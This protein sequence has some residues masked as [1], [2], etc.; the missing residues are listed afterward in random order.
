MNCSSL[1]ISFIIALASLFFVSCEKDEE[2]RQLN[3]GDLTGLGGDKWAQSQIDKWLLDSL[4]VPYNIAVKYKWDQFEL[5]ISRTLVPPDEARVVPM[6]QVLSDVWIKPYVAEAGKIFFNKF[7]PKSFI[8][9]G[10]NSYNDNGSV[11][12]GTAEGGRKIVLYAVNKFRVKGDAGYN[13]TTDSSFLKTFFIQTIHHEFAHILHQNVMYPQGF[14]KVNPS[15][16]NGQNWINVSDGN[17]RRDGFVT[18]YASSAY[19][20]DFAETVAMLLING[21]A[22]FDYIV[23]SIPVGTSVNGTTREEAQGYLRAKEAYVVDYFKQTYS[24]DFYALQARCRAALNKY[25]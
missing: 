13:P 23:N 22:G 17:A 1:K 3:P 5:D 18:S 2:L 25:L 16:Y 24:V 20:D 8:L 10:S 6:W 11:I 21:K 19:D 15:L 4:T 12:L 9:V 7:S 14:K